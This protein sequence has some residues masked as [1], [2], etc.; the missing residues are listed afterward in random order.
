MATT[1][2]KPVHSPDFLKGKLHLAGLLMAELAMIQ[3]RLDDICDESNT[4]LD[5]INEV[6]DAMVD[7][8]PAKKPSKTKS[9]VKSPRRSKAK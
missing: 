4:E 2:R 1:K 7:E 8:T 3:D 6:S 9:V 5:F